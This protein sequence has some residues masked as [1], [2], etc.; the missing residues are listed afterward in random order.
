[1][2][3]YLERE[4]QRGVARGE[5]SGLSTRSRVGVKRRLFRVGNTLGFEWIIG[6]NSRIF[7]SKKSRNP[8]VLA[9]RG[10]VGEECGLHAPIGNITLINVEYN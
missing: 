10:V 4:K 3:L 1:M 7:L 6:R 8:P 5:R 9:F 2:L